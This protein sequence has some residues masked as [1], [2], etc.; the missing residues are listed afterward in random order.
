MYASGE[1]GLACSPKPDRKDTAL[2]QL[3]QRQSQALG[4]DFT[5]R[6]GS[7]T[8]SELLGA[9][10]FLCSQL[11]D[12]VM[13]CRKPRSVSLISSSLT[14][15]NGTLGPSTPTT[16]VLATHRVASTPARYECAVG[17]PPPAVKV[18]HHHHADIGQH[19]LCLAN[20]F[21]T[22]GFPPLVEF[23]SPSPYL[24]VCAQCPCS[25]GLALCPEVQML[26]HPCSAHPGSLCRYERGLYFTDTQLFPAKV[27][28]TPAPE[29]SLFVPGTQLWQGLQE[30]SKPLVLPAA[31]Q[32]HP[33]PLSSAAG[34]Q[35]RASGVQR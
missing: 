33:N 32:Q 9:H 13:S 12:Q 2:Q 10:S 3:L 27:L 11:R 7:R 25:Q 24:W 30:R 35:W 21:C 34:R 20:H 14:A 15:A 16:C 5:P 19:V 6:P 31:T 22:P 18:P 1:M 28:E 4:K 8:G 29:Q 26:D 23:P 17:Q